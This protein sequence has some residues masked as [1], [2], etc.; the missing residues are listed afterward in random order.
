MSLKSVQESKAV[1]V[2][3]I[4]CDQ[5]LSAIVVKMI[6]NDMHWCQLA[7]K[8]KWQTN[9]TRLCWLWKKMIIESLYR[10]NVISSFSFMIWPIKAEWRIYASVTDHHG[11]GNGLLPGRCQVIIWTNVMIILIW[12]LG[13]NFSEILI[14]LKPFS[15]KKMHLKM[16]FAK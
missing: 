6:L 15:M 13:T 16:L 4:A 10:I 14:E 1:Y 8:T 2:G 12:P 7:P 11:S 3:T 9:I 5:L